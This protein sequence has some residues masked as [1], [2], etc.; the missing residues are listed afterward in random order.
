MLN[1]LHILGSLFSLLIGVASCDHKTSKDSIV[2]KDC[3]GSYLQ[4]KG[5]DFRVCNESKV[6]NIP[7][8]T[9]VIATF[10]SSSTCEAENE[11]RCEMYHQSE[12]DIRISKIRIR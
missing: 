4:I 5:S 3:T 2:I 6:E 8:G 10:R 1:R 12:G 9:E 11:I 7:N